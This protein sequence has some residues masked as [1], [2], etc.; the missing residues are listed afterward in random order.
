MALYSLHT[1][2]VGRGQKKSSA[3]QAAAYQARENLYDRVTQETYYASEKKYGGVLGTVIITPQG[4]PS[5]AK[6]RKEL[7]TQAEERDNR[8]NS[9]FAKSFILGLQSE[10]TLEQNKKLLEKFI[11][12]NFKTRGLV[13]DVAI[14]KPSKEGDKRN[15][16]AH[17]LVS[18]RTMTPLGWGEKDREID[19]KDF[20][21]GLRQS[22]ADEIN[23]ALTAAGRPERVSHKSLEERGIARTPQQHMGA[24]ATAIQRKGR[25][26]DRG[27]NKM[28]SVEAVK[29]ALV[30]EEGKMDKNVFEQI[31]EWL[32]DE[33]NN[34]W[35]KL[36]DVPAENVPAVVKFNQ[37]TQ[38]EKEIFCTVMIQN[39]P[40]IGEELLAEGNKLVKRKNGIDKGK[41][42]E[43]YKDDK[44]IFDK[45]R[46]LYNVL[47]DTQKPDEK[48]HPKWK[49]LLDSF[50]NDPA[51]GQPYFRFS[52][53]DH[54]YQIWTTINK[55]F[56]ELKAKLLPPQ[57]R[58]SDR[59]KATVKKPTG[60]K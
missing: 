27:K 16:H 49:A 4:S 45:T 5:W 39:R 30:D 56:N 9:R 1:S 46:E 10:L 20:L 48:D 51:T 15:I 40:Y 19:R 52:Y 14:H 29:S 59:N 58:D 50:Y 55:K 42:D 8:K 34:L 22:W 37:K 21:K 32:G 28:F 57:V 11:Y 23:N 54:R 3:V 17:L 7:W 60:R 24:A 6:D 47:S 33:Q 2:P 43:E 31:K 38:T 41:F 35:T 36:V 13:V 25:D 18:T 44:R 53:K 26:P 12:K